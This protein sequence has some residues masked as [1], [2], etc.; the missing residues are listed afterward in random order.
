MK[1]SSKSGEFDLIDSSTFSGHQ[2]AQGGVLVCVAVVRHFAGAVFDGG[3]AFAEFVRDG[4]VGA[5]VAERG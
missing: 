3:Q 5:G 4:L 2:I 1:F